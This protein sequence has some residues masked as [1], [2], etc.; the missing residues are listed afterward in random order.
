MLAPLRSRAARVAGVLLLFTVRPRPAF[1]QSESA[2]AAT[3]LAAAPLEIDWQGPED[4]ARGPAVQAKVL[5]LLGNQRAP[6]APIRVEVKVQHEKGS[7]FVAELTTSAGA[8]GG[9]KRLEGESCDAIALAS[10]VVIALSIDPSASL[11]A[12]APPEEPKPTPPRKRKRPPP[13]PPPRPAGPPRE[14]K[15]Y[16]FGSVGVLFQL[17]SQPAAFTAAGVGLRYRRLSLEL[18][19]AVYQTRDVRR[20]DRP[21]LGA[22]LQL[23]TGD[24]LGCY[25]ALPF[26]LGAVELC[27]GARIEYL[28]ATAFGASNPGSASVLLGSVLAAL[29][30][31]LRPTSWFS[32]TFDAGLAVRPFHPTFV[33]LGVGD[34][35]EIPAL[36]S[37]MRTGLALEF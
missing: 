9:S 8:G 19:G 1:G 12:E 26:A 23:A 35:Y 20:A 36:S 37:Y 7:R 11:D 22:E 13:A 24:L 33:L 16:L 25:A 3:T 21:K 6:G 32:A 14:T 5:R 17:L 27:P 28:S 4:C 15:A 30:G 2:E 10:A 31:R 18:G 34:V 29:R